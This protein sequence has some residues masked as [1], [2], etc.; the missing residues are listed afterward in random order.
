MVEEWQLSAHDTAKCIMLQ[1]STQEAPAR[2]VGE[3]KSSLIYIY[4]QEGIGQS[5]QLLFLVESWDTLFYTCLMAMT[6]DDMHLLLGQA[7]FIKVF[8][9]CPINFKKFELSSCSVVKMTWKDILVLQQP[10]L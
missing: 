4:G 9:I 5:L 3:N 7:S 8:M 6:C 2:M 1:Q 10:L